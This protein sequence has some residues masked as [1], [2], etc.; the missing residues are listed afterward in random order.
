MDIFTALLITSTM[1]HTN[2]QPAEYLKT[3]EVTVCEGFKV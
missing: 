3:Y 2:T 1:S